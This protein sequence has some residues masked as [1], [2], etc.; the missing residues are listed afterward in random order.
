VAVTLSAFRKGQWVATVLFGVVAAIFIYTTIVTV[1]EEPDGLKIAALFILAI[2][3]VS[4]VSRIW[5]QTE[6]RTRHVILDQ[7]AQEIVDEAAD[8]EIRF[9]AHDTDT[10]TPDEYAGKETEQRQCHDIKDDGPVIFLEVTVCDPS[11]FAPDLTITG[12][13][14]GRHRVLRAQS[15]AVPN[16]IAAFLLY[17]RDRWGAVP[18]VYFAWT[19]GSP[20]RHLAR[21]LLSGEGDIAP[22]THEVLRRAEPTSD[23]RPVV[24]VA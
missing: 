23:R 20:M 9:I 8:G 19:E 13:R 22:V 17:V 7:A 16:A 14:V 6:L 21:Y 10:L 3:V 18:H 12:H 2:V 5:R 11:E 4:I 15:A 1:A 24:H